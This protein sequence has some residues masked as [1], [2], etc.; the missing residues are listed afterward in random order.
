MIS[1]LKVFLIMQ[2]NIRDVDSFVVAADLILLF[3][4]SSLSGVYF[5]LLKS[6]TLDGIDKID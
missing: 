4:S 2:A 3:N 1:E 6:D 5:L